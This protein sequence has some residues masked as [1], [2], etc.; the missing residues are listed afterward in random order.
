MR[1]RKWT[2]EEER[3]LR[4]LVS[5]GHP[6]EV[7][8]KRFKKRPKAVQVK[9]D[10][11]GLIVDVDRKVC[12]TITT[13]KLEIP[14]DLLSA[15]RTLKIM[16]AAVEAAAKP[17]LSRIELQRLQLVSNLARFYKESLADYLDYR[18]VEAELLELRKLYGALAKRAK[19]SASG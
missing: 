12:S 10:R 14:G 1:G 7:I 4:E 3:E 16:S 17:G 6:V 2:V 9:I 13:G 18:R 19:V 11:L 15:E 8:A 5:E